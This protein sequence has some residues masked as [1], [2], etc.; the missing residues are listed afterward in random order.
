[1]AFLAESKAKIQQ[2]YEFEELG[3]ENQTTEVDIIRLRLIEGMYDA[4]HRYKIM[5]QLQ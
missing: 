3:Q 4:S 1:M 2:Y 5:E